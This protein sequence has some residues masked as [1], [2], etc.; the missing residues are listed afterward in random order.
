M[1]G[2]HE[3]IWGGGATSRQQFDF[4]AYMP[5]FEKW[6]EAIAALS[7]HTP[8]ETQLLSSMIASSSAFQQTRLLTSLELASPVLWPLF[9]IVVSWAMLFFCGF[10][11]LSGRNG[12]CAAALEQDDFRSTQTRH[13]LS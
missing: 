1:T 12:A 7:P 2:A 6:N 5:R 3:A 9:V 11:V 8:T 4:S 13:Q 10:G